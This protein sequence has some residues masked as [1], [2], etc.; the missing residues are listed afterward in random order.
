MNEN[1]L[2]NWKTIV[3]KPAN[4]DSLGRIDQ[5]ELIR[6]LGGGGFGTVFL[7]RDTESEVD[8]AVK[9]LPP[10]VKFNREEM[11][12]IRSNFRLVH[13]LHHPH[14]AAALY[15]HPAKNV[16]YASNDV[17]MK[18]RVS[19]GDTLLVMAYAPGVTLSQWRKQFPENKVPLEK[20]IEITRQ[21][22]DALDYAHERKVVHRDVKPANVMIETDSDGKVTARVLDFGL[23]AEIR[24]SMGRVSQEIHDTSGTRPYMAPEQWLGGK[25][26]P[27]TDQYS[28][29]VLFHELVT[30]AVPF[31]SVFQTGDPVVM[32]NVVGREAPKLPSDLP[33]SVRIALA[34]ALA[35]TP[36]ERFSSCL[37][38][39]KAIEGKVKVKSPSDGKSPLPK[40]AGVLLAALCLGGGVWY[41]QDA[42]A[43]KQARIEAP[44][45]AAEEREQSAE[46]AARE[47]E[48]KAELEVFRLYSKAQS[49]HDLINGESSEI[50]EFFATEI[51]AFENDRRAGDDA[52]QNS[53]YV[54]ATNF[55][56]Q[57]LSSA[58]ALKVSV[59]KY[60]ECKELLPKIERAKQQ[61]DEANAAESL[62]SGYKAAQNAQGA[63]LAT[64]NAKRF[65][66]CKGKSR[67]AESLFISLRTDV[68]N[69]VLDIAEGHKNNERWEQCKQEAEKVLGWDTN[70]AKAIELKTEAEKHL[71]PSLWCTVKVGERD[72]S[73]AGCKVRID[74]KEFGL[75]FGWKSLEKG[76]SLNPFDIEYTECGKRYVGRF[77]GQYVDWAGEKKISIVLK[78]QTGPKHGDTKTLTLPGGATMEM[79]YCAP[80]NY[81]YGDEKTP[82]RMEHGFWLGKYEVTQTQWKS[83][84]GENPSYFKGDDRLPVESV[85][86][87]DCK[88]F[89]QRVN[90][91]N[92]SLNARLP[93]EREWEYACRAGTSTKYSWGDALNGDK[94]NCDGNYPYG[95][96]IKGPYREKTVTV[97]S[98][99]PNPWG[100]YNMHGNVWEWCEDRYSASGD[101][102]VLRG[103]SWGEGA[104]N[105]RSATRIWIGPGN[106]SNIIGFRLACSAGPRE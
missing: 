66:E 56:M 6:E 82:S 59:T 72:L 7:A 32:M 29:A 39:V 35:K 94:A 3:D 78:E 77:P 25:Q 44:A 19:S 20:A 40:I 70:N 99:H 38:F 79:I 92:P 9:G 84:M 23:A 41:W 1:S 73:G 62:P 52:K 57:A 97:D 86:W 36:E 90:M 28:L 43:K 27:A 37:E 54:I 81:V 105:C 87:E 98:F 47:A 76:K 11:E 21:I 45:G 61:A 71:V 24:S 93:T 22:A 67:E 34:R 58:T 75:P 88:K 5:Y 13:D 26:G 65:D 53:K 10:F 18:L 64:F 74:G 85:S 102:R 33:K 14:I 100:F 80:G 49:A 89:I 15:L 2:G 16:S 55:Y 50:K 95:T 51:R 42:K 12:N 48:R 106:R 69:A 8:V 63:A 103:G 101:I 60:H 4:G 104:G 17:G 83:V 31:E 96:E 30:G 68:I 91:E 46:A